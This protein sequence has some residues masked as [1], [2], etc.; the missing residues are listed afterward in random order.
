MRRLFDAAV[1]EAN[2]TGAMVGN[3]ARGLV[4]GEPDDAANAFAHRFLGDNREDLRHDRKAMNQS[5]A[6]HRI[7]SST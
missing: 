4:T 7:G 6:S 1:A 2:S 5:L 3:F